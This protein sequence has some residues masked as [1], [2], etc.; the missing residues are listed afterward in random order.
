[1]SNYAFHRRFESEMMNTL[2]THLFWTKPISNAQV[3]LR[4]LKK[5]ILAF[6]GH[7]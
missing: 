7:E 6:F 3:K 1:M 2:F 4:D 5:Y